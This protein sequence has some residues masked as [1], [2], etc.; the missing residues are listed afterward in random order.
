MK[1]FVHGYECKEEWQQMQKGLTPSVKSEATPNAKRVGA[2]INMNGSNNE[3]KEESHN[4]CEE[5]SNNEYE[6]VNMIEYREESNNKEEDE[7][8]SEREEEDNT[9]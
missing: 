1:D 4:V 8:N 6:E 5:E 3:H 2:I 7:S 9:T